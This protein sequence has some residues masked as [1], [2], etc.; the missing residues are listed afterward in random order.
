MAQFNTLLIDGGF[1]ISSTDYIEHIP[2]I[3]AIHVLS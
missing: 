3:G 1:A 2:M